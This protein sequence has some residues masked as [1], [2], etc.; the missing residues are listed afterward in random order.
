MTPTG[1]LPNDPRWRAVGD[2][3]NE[4]GDEFD[5]LG[6]TAKEDIPVYRMLAGELDDAAKRAEATARAVSQMVNAA[7][8]RAPDERAGGGA[9]AANANQRMSLIAQQFNRIWADA[10]TK[11]SPRLNAMGDR[12]TGIGAKMATVA[13]ATRG[14][15]AAFD[16]LLFSIEKEIVKY[17]KLYDPTAVNLFHMAVNDLMAVIGRALVPL[18]N[19][20]TKGIRILADT[21]AGMGPEFDRLLRIF[22]GIATVSATVVAAI[23]AIAGALYILANIGTGGLV[24]VL[25][26]VVGYLVAFGQAGEQA[27][28]MMKSMLAVWDALS[29]TFQRVIRAVL[30]VWDV[31]NSILSPVLEGMGQILATLVRIFNNLWDTVAAII[32]PLWNVVKAVGEFL[33]SVARLGLAIFNLILSI[34]EAITSVLKPLGGLAGS[35][36]GVIGSVFESAIRWIS[37]FVNALTD[38]INWIAEKVG[39][40]GR[41]IGIEKDDTPRKPG[42]SAGM[43]IQQ[44]Q[45]SSIEELL[46]RQ[47]AAA[48]MVGNTTEDKSLGYQER[49][50]R[51]TEQIARNT[52]P[53]NAKSGGDKP[54][55]NGVG[56]PSLSKTGMPADSWVGGDF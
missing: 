41:L 30:S 6:Q 24:S 4:M 12:L 32:Q 14:L 9:A 17:V 43:A 55:F 42:A 18:L 36:I 19:Q 47:R 10:D 51:A 34:G 45:I 37:K 50:T 52:D 31:V 35:I 54:Q 7:G 49:T 26:A 28:R 27:G 23:T 25:V 3:I 11:T 16:V 46:N 38:F 2:I 20:F 44:A 48:Y 15:S 33:G 5:K 53:A 40:I 8:H 21:M 39:R 1:P 13:A 22:F 29:G 56:P